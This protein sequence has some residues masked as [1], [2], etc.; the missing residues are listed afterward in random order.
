MWRS[1][2]QSIGEDIETTNKKYTSWYFENNEEDSNELV[3]L[4]LKGQKRATA[5]AL[6]SY[7]FDN[8]PI[9]QES[10]L[11]IVTDWYGNAKCIIQ[12]KRINIVPYKDVDEDF[13]KI[14]GEGDCSLEYWRR[15]HERYFKQECTRIGKVFTEDMLVICEEFEVVYK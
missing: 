5:S 1:Y 10:D 14:E 15:G 6:W 7:Q 12:T 9:P 3:E 2:L 13:V 8:E 4:V 11:S